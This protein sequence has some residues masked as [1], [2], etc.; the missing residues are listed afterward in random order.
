MALEERAERE[1]EAEGERDS[2]VKGAGPPKR[3]GGGLALA[4]APIDTGSLD[5]LAPLEHEMAD[6]ADGEPDELQASVGSNA[7]LRLHMQPPPLE[8][9]TNATRAPDAGP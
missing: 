8:R 2:R 6:G 9:P 5:Q 1:A 4:L 7:P 3:G